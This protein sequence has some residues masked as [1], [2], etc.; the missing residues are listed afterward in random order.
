[1]LLQATMYFFA[2]IG[3]SYPTCGGSPNSSQELCSLALR[4]HKSY[5]D[6]FFSPCKTASPE[7]PTSFHS[8]LSA[9]F[10]K[11]RAKF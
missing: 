3:Y 7:F 9:L 5:N 11:H 10:F 6:R 2:V 8:A 4:A 1:L